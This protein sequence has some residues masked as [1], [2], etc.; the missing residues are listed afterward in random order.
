MKRIFIVTLALLLGIAFATSAFAAN[1]VICDTCTNKSTTF[2]GGTYLPSAKVTVDVTTDSVALA[3][4]AVS[5]HSG[6]STNVDAGRQF[7]TLSISPQIL[8]GASESTPGPKP[9]TSEAALATPSR[10]VTG[11]AAGWTQ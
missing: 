11:G 4:C 8:W 7:G 2:G 5:Q 9:C 10:G 3:Y 6:A 1:K